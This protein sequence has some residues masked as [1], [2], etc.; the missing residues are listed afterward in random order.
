MWIDALDNLAV[1]LQHEAQ[2][3]V[4]SRMLWPKVDREITGSRGSGW[5]RHGI[6]SEIAGS[7]LSHCFAFS[8]PGNG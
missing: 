7:R 5:L 3:A 4:G 2:N 1:K 8:S 6:D